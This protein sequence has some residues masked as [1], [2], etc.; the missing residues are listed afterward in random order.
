MKLL[1]FVH[2]LVLDWGQGMGERLRLRRH[3]GWSHSWLEA[4]AELQSAASFLLVLASTTTS[5]HPRP[6]TPIAMQLLIISIKV[7]LWL[8]LHNCVLSLKPYS[9]TFFTILQCV[10][11]DYVSTILRVWWIHTLF[12]VWRWVMTMSDPQT[13]NR[14]GGG[15]Q[16]YLNWRQYKHQAWSGAV[17][18][19]SWV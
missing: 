3:G 16:D 8:H 11:L 9:S 18:Y 7:N 15:L 5:D 14:P 13:D 19:L 4:E 12:L 17:Q 2:V 6:Q 1:L 10:I